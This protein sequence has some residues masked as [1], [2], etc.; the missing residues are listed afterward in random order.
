VKKLFLSI[1]LFILSFQV[2]ALF[3]DGD[4]MGFYPYYITYPEHLNNIMMLDDADNFLYLDCYFM[5]GNNIDLGGAEWGSI[6]GWIQIETEEKQFTGNNDGNAYK[7][8]N[9]T[10]NRPAE[11]FIGWNF[12]VT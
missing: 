9:L 1:I 7:I 10:V 11:D 6:E 2:N 5:Q 3:S 12:D 8:T 4:G